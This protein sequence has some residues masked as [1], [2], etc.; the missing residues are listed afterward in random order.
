M[1]YVRHVSYRNSHMTYESSPRP[2]L[3]GKK[4]PVST[5]LEPEIYDQIVAVARANERPVSAEIRRAVRQ[6]VEAA[7]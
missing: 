7:A 4:V 3:K 1:K 5:F 2:A 6:Y